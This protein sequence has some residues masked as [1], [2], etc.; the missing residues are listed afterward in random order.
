[1]HIFYFTFFFFNSIKIALFTIP[2][3]KDDFVNEGFLPVSNL[4][5]LLLI[6]GRLAEI[7]RLFKI[8]YT[9]CP[10]LDLI[11]FLPESTKVCAVIFF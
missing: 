8:G 7:I 11:E 5:Q 2:L 10:V 6:N 3:F 4:T 9:R 1:M